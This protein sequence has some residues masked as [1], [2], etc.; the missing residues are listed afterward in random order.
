[1]CPAEVLE[2][3]VTAGKPALQI[4]FIFEQQIFSTKVSVTEYSKHFSV[5]FWFFLLY[6]SKEKIRVFL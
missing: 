3:N 6:L 2:T 4:G 1:M 5:F